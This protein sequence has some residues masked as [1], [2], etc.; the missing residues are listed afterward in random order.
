MLF[1][2]I[3]RLL[4]ILLFTI[5]LPK[6]SS[7]PLDSLGD[8]FSFGQLLPRQSPD[9]NQSEPELEF[10]HQ[11]VYSNGTLPTE[12]DV[13]DALASLEDGIKTFKDEIVCTQRQTGGYQQHESEASWCKNGYAIRIINHT[14]CSEEDGFTPI[15]EK[16]NLVL[17]CGKRLI[18]HI[19]DNMAQPVT[20]KLKDPIL[21]GR[22]PCYPTEDEYKILGEVNIKG[23]ENW[24]VIVTREECGKLGPVLQWTHALEKFTICSEG[25]VMPDNV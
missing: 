25:V 13:S 1:A 12:Q 9:D 14:C 23:E 4:P 11:W 7:L 19:G 22:D 16:C 5:H 8:P 6:A 20:R 10:S 15:T 18:E 24:S 21:D 17:S 2:L 3:L